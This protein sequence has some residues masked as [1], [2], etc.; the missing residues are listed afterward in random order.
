MDSAFAWLDRHQWMLS[1]YAMV[2]A[3]EW[4]DSLRS[5]KRFPQLKR[6]LGIE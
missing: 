5:D 6:R 2:Q 3:A 4:L 1:E